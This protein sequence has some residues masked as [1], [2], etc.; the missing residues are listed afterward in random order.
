MNLAEQA[1]DAVSAGDRERLASILERCPLGQAGHVA[2]A[3]IAA[4]RPAVSEPR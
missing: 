1:T 4:T 2:N 3:I